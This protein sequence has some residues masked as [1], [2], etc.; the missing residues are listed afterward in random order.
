MPHGGVA[1]NIVLCA[2]MCVQ[3]GQRYVTARVE[4]GWCRCGVRLLVA[5]CE[6]VVWCGGVSL[7]YGVRCVVWCAIWCVMW[8]GVHL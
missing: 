2:G 1:G 8:W 7:V 3:Q 5:W 4:V 6:C